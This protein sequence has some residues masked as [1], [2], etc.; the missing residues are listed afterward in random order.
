MDPVMRAVRLLQ[1]PY[2]PAASVDPVE[3]ALWD[4]YA[5]SGRFHADVR[6]CSA[7]VALAPSSHAYPIPAAETLPPRL[8]IDIIGIG[9]DIDIIDDDIII[10]II[11][12]IV[13]FGK[14]AAGSFLVATKTAHCQPASTPCCSTCECTNGDITFVIIISVVIIIISVV[15]SAVDRRQTDAQTH[16][17]EEK[18]P[19]A[20]SPTSRASPPPPTSSSSASPSSAS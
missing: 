11:D 7:S 3:R 9:I 13:N 12:D 1:Q 5:H 16:H 6:S 10:V 14:D 19:Q 20:M 17:H 4:L 15:V 8:S 18:R 2:P